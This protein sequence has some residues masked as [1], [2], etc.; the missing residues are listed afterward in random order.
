MKVVTK[1][2]ALGMLTVIPG[3]QFGLSQSEKATGQVALE[4]SFDLDT[5][6]DKAL[7]FFTPEGER[8]W[9]K[10][11]NPQALYPPGG[12]VMFQTNAGSITCTQR[13]RKKACNL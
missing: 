1:L 13:H 9:V 6:A 3:S 8:T 10:D 5:S 7:Q 4:G 12:A 11:W 2:F